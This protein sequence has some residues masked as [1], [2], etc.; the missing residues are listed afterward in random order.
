MSQEGIAG[1]FLCT[2]GLWGV[3]AILLMCVANKR[4]TVAVANQ[5]KRIILVML[6]LAI[7]SAVA[8]VGLIMLN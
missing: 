7:S 6:M 3:I 5:A 4:R 1:L 8:G 2:V